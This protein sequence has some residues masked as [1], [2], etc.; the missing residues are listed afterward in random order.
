MRILHVITRG[1]VGGA[2][3]H[4]AQLAA[5]QAGNG[6]DV[7][8]VAGVAG[9][10]VDL[11]RQ[12][13]VA[14]EI[15]P[16]LGA[17]RASGSLRRAY[18]EVAA[19]VAAVEPDI[20]HGHS[21][22]GGLLARAAARRH[23]VPA[24]YTAHG[25]PFQPGA[26]WRQRV[27]SYVGEYIGARLGDAVICVTPHERDMALRS[28]VVRRSNVFVVP[29]G[30]DDV[31]RCRPPGAPQGP[32]RMV[33]VARFAPPKAQIELIE[34]LAL[35]ADV[36]WELSF[37]GDGPD[38]EPARARAA[39]LLGDRVTFLG[40]RDDVADLLAGSDVGLLWSGY[41]GLPLALL[42]AM[43]AGLCCVANDLPGVRFLFGAQQGGVIVPRDP[44]G[45]ERVIRTLLTDR[46]RLASLASAAR[47]RYEAAFTIEEMAANIRE[48]YDGVLSGR[49]R[50]RCGGS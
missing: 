49:R 12:R 22:H 7:T 38:L 8:I 34:R 6:D 48:V 5:H 50:A 33:M 42:E 35:V 3:T 17:A 31:V 15:A 10:A 32:V 39:A 13:G 23:G 29:N 18:R 41:E 16:A 4:V 47:R 24:V 45:F 19:Q 1:D 27:S 46:D 40:H 30:L 11:A 37:V 14:V 2:Q 43:R 26:P 28:R 9:P 44:A 36:P 21:S 25:W 20:V